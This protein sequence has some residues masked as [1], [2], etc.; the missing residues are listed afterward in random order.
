[1]IKRIKIMVIGLITLFIVCGCNNHKENK[2]IDTN[3]IKALCV[4]DA[5]SYKK[6]RWKHLQIFKW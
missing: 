5:Y 4:Y 1:M 2:I 6:R 3:E